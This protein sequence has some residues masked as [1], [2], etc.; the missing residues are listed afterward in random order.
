MDQ[1]TNSYSL[2][3]EDHTV[4]EFATFSVNSLVTISKEIVEAWIGEF[5]EYV[6]D[7]IDM[8]NAYYIK[9]IVVKAVKSNDKFYLQDINKQIVEIDEATFSKLFAIIC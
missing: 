1:E 2:S 8:S 7:T 4:S 9:P 5:F 3:D 6:R